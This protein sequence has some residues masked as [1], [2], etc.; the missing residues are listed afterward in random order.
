MKLDRV[1][2]DS[3]LAVKEVEEGDSGDARSAASKS[4]TPLRYY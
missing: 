1:R 3:R 2:R 4:S